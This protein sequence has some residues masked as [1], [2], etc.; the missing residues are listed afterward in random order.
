MLRVVTVKDAKKDHTFEEIGAF[1][2][3]LFYEI[4]NWRSGLEVYE[5]GIRDSNGKRLLAEQDEFDKL[6]ETVYVVSYNHNKIVNG[7]TRFQS[8]EYPYMLQKDCFKNYPGFIN[9][10]LP[11]SPHV[12]EASRTGFDPNADKAEQNRIV[13]ELVTAFFEF[14]IKNNITHMLGTMSKMVIY[15]LFHKAGCTGCAGQESKPDDDV[16]YLGNYV[17]M[18]DS[19]SG[20]IDKQTTAA[21]LRISGDAYK[22]VMETSGTSTDLLYTIAG[23]KILPKIQVLPEIPN[24]NE[25]IIRLNKITMR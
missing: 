14:G 13:K 25:K 12:W 23:D 24:I 17:N 8:T 19:I 4:R 15:A 1:R 21:M 3:K 11:V 9:K 20:A 5:T 22:R 10:K 2:Y 18:P 16:S 6:N 7:I